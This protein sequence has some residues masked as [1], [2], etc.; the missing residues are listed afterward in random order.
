MNVLISQT[1]ALKATLLTN[2]TK[3][4]PKIDKLTVWIL[5]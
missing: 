4:E 3:N 5:L 1:N 2:E